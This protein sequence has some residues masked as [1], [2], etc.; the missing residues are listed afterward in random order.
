M[1]HYPGLSGV[2]EWVRR[3]WRAQRLDSLRTML[4]CSVRVG[5]CELHPT[6]AYQSESFASCATEQGG[7]GP[8]E[9]SAV[10]SCQDLP[11]AFEGLSLQ[12]Q[13]LMGP[14]A[15]QLLKTCSAQLLVVSE[16]L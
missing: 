16:A 8:A 9:T 11:H 4:H 5:S 2:V 14:L 7:R 6:E 12:A 1:L 10:V 15:A 13:S 3:H